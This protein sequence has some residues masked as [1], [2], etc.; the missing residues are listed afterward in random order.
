[1]SIFS[2]YNVKNPQLL[3]PSTSSESFKDWKADL[4]TGKNTGFLVFLFLFK[5]SNFI[6]ANKYCQLFSFSN[7]HFIHFEESIC[8]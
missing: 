2:L 4:L 8:C 1:M 3:K 7:T 5:S 6:I